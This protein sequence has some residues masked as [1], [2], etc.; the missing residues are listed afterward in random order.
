MTGR[1]ALAVALVA[2]L[3]GCLG[4]L[5][6]AGTASPSSPASTPAATP[7]PTASLSPTATA[8]PTATPST[9]PSPTATATPT[10]TITPAQTATRTPLSESHVTR[11]LEHEGVGISVTATGAESAF[12]FANVLNATGEPFTD[13]EMLDCASASPFAR[14][15]TGGEVADATVEMAYD[16]AEILGDGTESELRVFAFNRTVQFYVPM[17]STV[18]AANDTVRATATRPLNFTTGQGEDAETV[19]PRV[20]GTA[21]DDVFVVMHEPTFWEFWED[22]E[23]PERCEAA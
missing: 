4:G 18:D 1:R 21:L 17:R 3:A 13:S 2:L 20:D 23:V 22:T 15:V 14:V 7:T 9:T 6:G 10:A 11:V 5:G 8:A 12:E 19:T 16:P